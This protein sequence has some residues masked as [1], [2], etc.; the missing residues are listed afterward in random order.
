MNTMFLRI[1]K[2]QS[3]KNKTAKKYYAK[4]ETSP[5]LN[6]YKCK[7]HSIQFLID[8]PQSDFSFLY[9]VTLFSR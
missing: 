5:F 9:K 6:L 1:K 8:V 7:L 2:K 4:Y 3:L